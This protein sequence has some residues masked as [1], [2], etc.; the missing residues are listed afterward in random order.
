VSPT[1][2]RDRPVDRNRNTSRDEQRSLIRSNNSTPILNNNIVGWEEISRAY[3]L[4]RNEFDNN[5]VIKSQ[6]EWV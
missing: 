5:E 1:N 3:G 2:I 4:W 6:I